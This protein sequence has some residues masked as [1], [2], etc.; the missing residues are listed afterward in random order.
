MRPIQTKQALL[1]ESVIPTT[2]KARPGRALAA[3]AGHCESC[4]HCQDHGPLMCFDATHLVRAV[5][6]P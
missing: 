5:E 2:A 6:R 1:P 3:L 4:I